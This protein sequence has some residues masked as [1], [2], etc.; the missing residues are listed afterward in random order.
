[1]EVPRPEQ[2]APPIGEAYVHGHV[3]APSEAANDR[4]YQAPLRLD[5][6]MLEHPQS[7]AHERSFRAHAAS[8]FLSRPYD[9]CRLIRIVDE[10]FV[11]GHSG[12]VM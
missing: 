8:S 10:P 2:P 9:G 1:M 5:P 4:S 12:V 7:D 3:P 11:W 6:V